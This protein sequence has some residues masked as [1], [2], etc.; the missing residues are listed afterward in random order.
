MTTPIEAG[1]LS[2]EGQ[3]PTL[4]RAVVIKRFFQDLYDVRLIKHTPYNESDDGRRKWFKHL[5]QT[6]PWTGMS[7]IKK[8]L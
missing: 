2:K 8:G 3:D 4:G 7:Y 5:A 6:D 1:H